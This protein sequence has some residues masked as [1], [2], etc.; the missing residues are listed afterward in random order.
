MT[1]FGHGR[2][3]CQYHSGTGSHWPAQQRWSLPPNQKTSAER[4]V[5][6]GYNTVT[7][8]NV[9]PGGPAV[10]PFP[11][12]DWDFLGKP[13]CNSLNLA[14][15]P[16]GQEDGRCRCPYPPTEATVPFLQQGLTMT[17]QTADVSVCRK[18]GFKVVQVQ[19]AM[20]PLTRCLD[21]NAPECGAGE[22]AWAVRSTVETIR[23]GSDPDA[24]GVGWDQYDTTITFNADPMLGCPS[25]PVTAERGQMPGGAYAGGA[26]YPCDDVWSCTPLLCGAWGT[27]NGQLTGNCYQW[28]LDTPEEDLNEDGSWSP[29][30]F[31]TVW[32]TRPSGAFPRKCVSMV[33]EFRPP[34]G[35]V[36][37]LEWSFCVEYYVIENGAA[38]ARLMEA[39][40]SGTG[41]LASW[42]LTTDYVAAHGQTPADDA[43]YPW[44][45]DPR[46]TVGPILFDL[47][48]CD[49]AQWPTTI[50]Q[51]ARTPA[52]QPVRPSATYDYATGTLYS[53]GSLPTE[54]RSVTVGHQTYKWATSVSVAGEVALG[55]DATESLTNLGNAI[56]ATDGTHG[57]GGSYIVERANDIA[58]ATLPVAD[59]K[60][61]VT[62]LAAACP[63]FY[64]L[65]VNGDPNLGW[66]GSVMTGHFAV[67]QPN[68]DWTYRG[69]KW[70]ERVVCD[71][72]QEC[73]VNHH[74]GRY[75][76][77]T[78]DAAGVPRAA[79]S[80]T[81]LMLGT[82]LYPGSSISYGVTGIVA[83]ATLDGSGNRG[84]T[85]VYAAG[86]AVVQ[87]H[88]QLKTAVRS[89][90]F[91]RPSDL[92]RLLM[93]EGD[94]AAEPPVACGVNAIDGADGAASVVLAGGEL[95]ALLTELPRFAVGDPVVVYGVPGGEGVWSVKSIAERAVVLEN[96]RENSG[97]RIAEAGRLRGPVTPR[98]AP[99]PDFGYG[100][101]GKQRFPHAW[102]LPGRVRVTG[103]S[104]TATPGQIAVSVADAGTLW[105]GD[106]VRFEGAAEECQVLAIT[107][108]TL[109][110]AAALSEVTE[111]LYNGCQ[112]IGEVTVCPPHWTWYDSRPKGTWWLV[113]VQGLGT[114]LP[115][116]DWW[117]PECWVQ[118]AGL[119]WDTL[120]VSERCTPAGCCGLNILNIPLPGEQNTPGVELWTCGSVAVNYPVECVVDPLY[121]APRDF[122]ITDAND[123]LLARTYPHP[124][125]CEPCLHPEEL[126]NPDAPGQTVSLPDGLAFQVPRVERAQ[127][128][129]A[130]GMAAGP[131]WLRPWELFRG[132]QPV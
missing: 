68:F 14:C 18:R 25:Q 51:P 58:R 9:L 39:L 33:I 112:V 99:A 12:A 82:V 97:A 110:L 103:A 107:G 60:L 53:N 125:Y 48:G 42:N 130:G 98:T 62:S 23:Y 45:T 126:E 7:V 67:G 121:Q 88:V 116:G 2:V 94:A 3:P 85:T 100:L 50:G 26:Y 6:L 55:E 86:G 57:A 109:T 111:Y 127:P 72:A 101:I 19:V 28:A 81:D 37:R 31:T 59:Q 13:N 32:F 46:L 49:G 73:W 114:G 54:G 124:P 108:Q 77:G 115:P 95:A 11:R 38:N 80:F 1:A 120:Q 40:S 64:Y 129:R 132:G 43:T 52:G 15:G 36:T 63:E 74:Y 93:V 41:K 102:P 29:D 113:S 66:D 128:D 35:P 118:P 84:K 119:D 30:P 89:H 104:A 91:Y 44:R 83:S 96:R 78:Q 21:G 8:P 20:P 92:D 70:E 22:R 79:T 117:G 75:V 5:A 47:I 17:D 123:V 76:D 122:P 106:Y 65:D 10:P 27:P 4:A 105:A 69:Y 87:K 24:G 71:V 90:N 61:V 56:N 34:S 131:Q 16:W